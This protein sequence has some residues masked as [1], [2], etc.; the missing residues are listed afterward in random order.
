[1]S[2][3][4]IRDLLMQVLYR[5]FGAPGSWR[6]DGPSAKFRVERPNL[7]GEC[8]VEGVLEYHLPDGTRLTHKSD[9]LLE[10]Q[11]SGSGPGVQN[12]VS[13]EIKHRS[14]V[15]DQFKCRSFD[16]LHMK[17]V[18][19]ARL[20][21]IMVFARACQGIGLDRARAICYPFDEFVG[22]D[23]IEADPSNVWHEL[24]D[25]LEGVLNSRLTMFPE[26]QTLEV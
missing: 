1:M 15:T 10:Y 4:D 26:S 7:L 6:S 12:Y 11:R 14:A 9:I 25:K 23:L 19:G 8:A 3:A 13:I 17:N 2:E 22:I 24:L 18:F 16:M 5:S 20:H 21:G